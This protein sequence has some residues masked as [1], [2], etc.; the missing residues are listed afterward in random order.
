MRGNRE[1]GR[2]ERDYRGSIPACA[3][4]PPAQPTLTGW[5]QVYPRVC[6]GTNGGRGGTITLEVYPRVCGG[7]SAIESVQTPCRGLSPRVRGTGIMTPRC[8]R[9]FGLSPRVRGNLEPPDAA[10]A[11]FGSIPA[12]AGEPLLIRSQDGQDKVYPRVCGGTSPISVRR[13]GAAGLSP[14]VRGNH[15]SPLIQSMAWRSIP[16]CAGEPCL[17]THPGD[18]QQVYPRVCGGTRSG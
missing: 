11:T 17:R 14:R 1:S 2:W 10:F 7:T 13:P 16:A 15:P 5:R 4:E 9:Y 18:A 6:G 3:G 12:C 8:V